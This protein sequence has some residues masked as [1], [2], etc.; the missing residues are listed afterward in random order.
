MLDSYQKPQ[1]EKGKRKKQA[2]TPHSPRE[3]V[4]KGYQEGRPVVV[5]SD[6]GQTLSNELRFHLF[7]TYDDL[8]PRLQVQNT[9]VG[10]Q[11]KKTRTNINLFITAKEK[12]SNFTIFFTWAHTNR[13]YVQSNTFN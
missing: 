4:M 3:S 10:L 2:K 1:K 13:D 7:T 8:H 11:P 6:A 5:L 12:S 9:A